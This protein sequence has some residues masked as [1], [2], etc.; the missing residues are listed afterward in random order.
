M[1][2]IN[3]NCY[4][5]NCYVKKVRTKLCFYRKFLELK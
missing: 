3:A 4:M 5:K 2:T 1:F